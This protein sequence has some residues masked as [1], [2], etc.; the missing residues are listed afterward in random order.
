MATQKKTQADLQEFSDEHLFYEIWM[1]CEMADRLINR[2]YQDDVTKNAYVESFVVHSRNL[3]DFLY[4]KGTKDDDAI[5]SDFE[6]TTPW[7]PPPM[8]TILNTWYPTRM[9]KHLAHLTFT[10]LNLYRPCYYNPVALQ[11]L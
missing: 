1:L 6:E 5:A 3:L 2:Q 8:D 4:D 10:R 7:N 11:Q 9:H